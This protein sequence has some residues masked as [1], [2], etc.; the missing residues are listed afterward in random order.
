MPLRIVSVNFI[1]PIFDKAK[2]EGIVS[3]GLTR[4]GKRFK[5]LVVDTMIKTPARGALYAARFGSSQGTGFTRAHRASIKGDP[6]SPDTMNLV[7][8]VKDQKKSPTAHEVYV[9]DSQAPY[10]KFLE[11]PRLDRLIMKDN[12]LNKFIATDLKEENERMARE[13]AGGS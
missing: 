13:L 12:L 3:R 1:D 5:I 9:D 7:R 8:S 6:P 11:R 10:G 2:R 4:I